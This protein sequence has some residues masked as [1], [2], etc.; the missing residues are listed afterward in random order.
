MVFFFFFF[1][2]FFFLVQSDLVPSFTF[3]PFHHT[4]YAIY[5][6]GT[7][8][9]NHVD[10]AERVWGVSLRGW[11]IGHFVLTN[12]GDHRRTER[13]ADTR[14]TEGRSSSSSS[15]HWEQT[16]PQTWQKVCWEPL[17][18]SSLGVVGVVFWMGLGVLVLFLGF[19]GGGFFSKK[20]KK[21]SS[22]WPPPPSSP[23]HC[24]G[25]I[26]CQPPFVYLPSPA[27]PL[28]APFLLFTAFCMKVEIC[29]DYPAW[30]QHRVRK[31]KKK[32]KQ[33]G[34]CSLGA[35]FD[36]RHKWRH[37]LRFKPGIP[38]WSNQKRDETDFSLFSFFFFFN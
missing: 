24:L 25:G 1:F 28:A 7:R 11:E 26:G 17:W 38:R 31:K 16:G 18:K 29:E 22:L 12:R 4:N 13:E 34:Y 10:V 33:R 5:T 30:G 23:P 36:S 8:I 32:Q 2:F 15:E 21:K 3:G 9:V 37:G 19:Y 27:F 20:K 14:K 6:L 35:D